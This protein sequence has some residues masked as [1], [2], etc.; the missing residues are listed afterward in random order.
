MPE[1]EKGWCAEERVNERRRDAAHGR[2]DHGLV[3]WLELGRRCCLLRL[4]EV[5]RLGHDHSCTSLLE[6]VG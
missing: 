6:V 5:V 4:F 2:H 1:E 3:A